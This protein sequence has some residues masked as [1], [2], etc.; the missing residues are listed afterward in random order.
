MA[1]YSTRFG[2][3][4]FPRNQGWYETDRESPFGS[5]RFQIN[6]M[7]DSTLW[8]MYL[9]EHSFEELLKVRHKDLV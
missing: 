9:T 2:Y 6:S 3:N 8:R 7:I 1:L 5:Q 4:S